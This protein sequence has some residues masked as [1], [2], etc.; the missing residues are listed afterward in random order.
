MSLRHLELEKAVGASVSRETFQALEQF[1]HELSRWSARINLVAPSTISELWSRHILD[2][3]FVLSRAPAGPLRWVD[4][5]SGGGLPGAVIAILVQDRPGSTVTLIES[6]AKKAAFLKTQTGTLRTPVTVETARIE[7]SRARSADYDVVTA[8]ALA[9]LPLLLSYAEPWL[10]RKSV[11]IFH[12]GRD[13][14]AELAAAQDIWSFDLVEHPGQIE[15][16]SVILEIAR[17]RRRR[18]KA[19]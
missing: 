15:A 5:G 18:D 2:S 10:S 17:L 12:K 1:A 16:D 8:R 19:E 4:I 14:R 11:G 9:P 6:N 13:Y 3:A 7:A